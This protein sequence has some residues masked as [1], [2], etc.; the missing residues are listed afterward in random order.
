MRRR[1]YNIL[2]WRPTLHLRVSSQWIS[3]C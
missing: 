3:A 1:R 2:E